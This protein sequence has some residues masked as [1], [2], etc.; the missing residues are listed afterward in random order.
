[1]MPDSPVCLAQ[2][3]AAFLEEWAIIPIWR[4]NSFMNSMPRKVRAVERAGW[5]NKPGIDEPV[6]SQ[7]IFISG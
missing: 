7:S 6:P 3:R 4:I 5:V 1:M 2:L